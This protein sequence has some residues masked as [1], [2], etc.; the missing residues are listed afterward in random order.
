MDKINPN[1]TTKIDSRNN[2]NFESGKNESLDE[3]VFK[4]P[5]YNLYAAAGSFSE[6]HT[7]REFTMIDVPK[8]FH[9]EGYFALRVLGESMNRRIP[10]G[11]ICIFKEPVVGGRS[12]KILLIENYNE[13]DPDIQT[14]FTVKTYISTKSKETDEDGRPKNVSIVLKPNS[15]DPKYEDLVYTEDSLGENRLNVVGEFVA[16]LS[17]K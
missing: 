8:Q 13:Q 6:M 3:Q 17:D 12:G 9:K 10:N 7:S 11:S 1:E 2:V 5:F 14:H 15:F 4:I 16:I